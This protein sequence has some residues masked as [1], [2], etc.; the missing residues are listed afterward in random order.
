[1]IKR[2]VGP[3]NYS[4]DELFPLTYNQSE[5][6]PRDMELRTPTPVPDDDVY[7][8]AETS[9]PVSVRPANLKSPEVNA[10]RTLASAGDMPKTVVSDPVVMSLTGSGPTVA[11]MGAGSSAD[12]AGADRCLGRCKRRSVGSDHAGAQ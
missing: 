6:G 12:Q 10:A 8:F 11:D 4:R 1:M 9:A 2:S 3:T 7:R 5:R